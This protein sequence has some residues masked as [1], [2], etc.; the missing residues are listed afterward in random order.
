MF[1]PRSLPHVNARIAHPPSSRP[2]STHNSGLRARSLQGPQ[3]GHI[4]VSW[5]VDQLLRRTS[6]LSVS[7]THGHFLLRACESTRIFLAERPIQ[8]P[9]TSRRR[10]SAPVRTINTYTSPAPTAPDLLSAC[11]A[12]FNSH[13]SRGRRHC[14]AHLRSQH[15]RQ[16]ARVTRSEHGIPHH[17][18]HGHHRCKAHLV[19]PQDSSVCHLSLGAP[20]THDSLGYHSH[21]RQHQAR[22]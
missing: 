2:I 10:A 13:T 17:R 9:T 18:H 12:L 22:E 20:V 16:G 4:V 6:R 19:H 7:A 14:A 21:L 5:A 11:L 15:H 8:R 3:T 1:A